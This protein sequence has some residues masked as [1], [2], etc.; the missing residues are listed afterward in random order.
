[1]YV[2]SVQGLGKQRQARWRPQTQSVMKLVDVKT[3]P[4]ALAK[5]SRC[6]FTIDSVDTLLAFCRFMYLTYRSGWIDPRTL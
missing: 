6:K 1:M 3:T 5:N 2:L 4:K